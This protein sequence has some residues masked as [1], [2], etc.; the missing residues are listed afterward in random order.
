[1]SATSASTLYVAEYDAMG[2][3]QWAFAKANH[4]DHI[5]SMIKSYDNLLKIENK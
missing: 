1:M 4:R 3:G 5:K 2:G